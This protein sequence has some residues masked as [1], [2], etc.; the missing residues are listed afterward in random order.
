MSDDRLRQKVDKLAA[1]EWDVVAI[2][3]RVKNLSAEGIR[4]R[5]LDPALMQAKKEDILDRVQFR[6]EAYNFILKNCAQG[7]A[8][9]LMEEFGLGNM[10]R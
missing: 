10:E 9:A 3:A 7:T 4:R 2:E 5:R 6:A 8:L 1:R